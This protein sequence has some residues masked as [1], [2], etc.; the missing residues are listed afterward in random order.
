VI[1]SD[2]PSS[3]S[4]PN[5]AAR[6][7]WFVRPA[8]ERPVVPMDAGSVAQRDRPGAWKSARFCPRV[9]AANG[10][11][12]SAARTRPRWALTLADREKISRDLVTG[13]SL[14]AIATRLQ[15]PPST[16]SREVAHNV[17][18]RVRIDERGQRLRDPSHVHSR[19]MMSC[20]ASSLRS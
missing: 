8:E 9:L 10:G 16:I 1:G 14:R 11:V 20:E 3:R 17:E 13:L 15:R 12:A 7:T 4:D 6:S 18:L 19:R 2:Q 5:D